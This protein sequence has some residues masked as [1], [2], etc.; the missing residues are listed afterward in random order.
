MYIRPVPAFCPPTDVESIGP[1]A[2]PI[3]LAPDIL[4]AMKLPRT[5]ASVAGLTLVLGFA[6]LLS[7]QYNGPE[8][9]EYDPI[10]DR[11][12]VSNTGDAS[13]KVRAQNG[14]VTDLVTEMEEPPYGLELVN[15]VLYACMG[16]GV[17][18]YDAVTAAPVFNVN[19]NASFL[20]GI[21]SDGSALFVTDF[22]DEKIFKIVIDTE[23]AS[24]LV[25]DTQGSPNGIVW[26]DANGRLVVVF[27]GNS[28]PIKAFDPSTGAAT[29]LVA[30]SGVGNIDGVTIDCLGNF[31]IASWSP[32]RLTRFEPTFTMAGVNT[33]I[34]GLNHPA[35]IDFDTNNNRVCIPNSGSNTVTLA[36]VGCENAVPE[37]RAITTHVIPNPTSGLVRFDPPLTTTEPYIVMDARGV[38][39]AVGNLAPRGMLDLGGLD[40]GVYLIYFSR[41]AHHVRVVKG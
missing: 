27:W 25:D 24:T 5:F 17:R 35:D 28:A 34:T 37:V 3:Y 19:L 22:S 20:N 8:S 26:D 4:P 16:S 39:I 41:L 30:N 31:L 7:A 6:P 18:G 14:T 15:G 40:A 13:I 21:T 36:P 33:G 9:V 1:T 38:L 11:Y 2:C 23:Q 10:G 32:D 29:T 12:F